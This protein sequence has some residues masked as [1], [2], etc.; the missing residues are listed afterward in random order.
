MSDKFILKGQNPVLCN[1]ILAWSSWFEKAD[2]C[3]AN[4]SRDG[5][6]VSTVF[7]ALDHSFA[8]GPPILFETMIFGGKE[9]GYKD[10]CSTWVEAEVMHGVACRLVWGDQA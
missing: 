3:V 5:I 10:R 2:R 6:R 7:L 1:D 9:D 4:T 8:D